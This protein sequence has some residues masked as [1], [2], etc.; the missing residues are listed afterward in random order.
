MSALSLFIIKKV[1]PVKKWSILALIFYICM[2]EKV[3]IYHKY[4]LTI[5]ATLILTGIKNF[6]WNKISFIFCC[7]K[8]TFRSL[9]LQIMF[10]WIFCVLWRSDFFVL[11]LYLRQKQ[12]ISYKVLFFIF[13]F[14]SEQNLD[15]QMLKRWWGG[16]G[17]GMEV[18]QD[19]KKF[20]NFKF[21]LYKSNITTKSLFAIFINIMDPLLR[22]KNLIPWIL[23]PC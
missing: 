7:W 3:E 15:S 23:N 4:L 21:L 8:T 5:I 2:D 1:S 16:V 10:L 6:D 22:I 9:V 17:G 12:E 20:L 19:H 11:F 13:Y 14:Y 18:K